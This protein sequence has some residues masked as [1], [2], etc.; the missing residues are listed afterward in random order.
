MMY[1]VLNQLRTMTPH[2]LHSLQRGKDMNSEHKHN[3]WS[4]YL[5]ERCFVKIGGTLFLIGLNMRWVAGCA[6]TLDL[7]LR[8]VVLT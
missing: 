5:S 8:L 2:S 3:F 6:L 7:T 4:E 1:Q